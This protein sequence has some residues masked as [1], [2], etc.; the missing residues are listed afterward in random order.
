M[1]ELRLAPAEGRL[2]GLADDRAGLQLQHHGDG[3]DVGGVEN[4]RAMR[5]RDRPQLGRR[6]QHMHPATFTAGDPRAVALADQVGGVA[7]GSVTGLGLGALLHLDRH[8]GVV[9]QVDDGHVSV[10]DEVRVFHETHAG[11]RCRI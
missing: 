3:G 5:Q 4:L 9:A 10:L 1:L 2:T 8:H 6:M 7:D 11:A